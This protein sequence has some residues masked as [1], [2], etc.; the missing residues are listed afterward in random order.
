MC[1]EMGRRLPTVGKPFDPAQ[2]DLRMNR[3]EAR[4][5]SSAPTN[6]R[7]TEPARRGAAPGKGDVNVKDA[8]LRSKSRRPL[9][10]QWQEHGQHWLCYE[11]PLCRGTP[12]EMWC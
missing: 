9:Q 7:A 8:R 2:R 6:P 3:A 10:I 12:R 4:F 11:K 5:T 1:G